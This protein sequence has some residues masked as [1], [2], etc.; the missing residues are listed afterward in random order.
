[1]IVTNLIL[2]GA[3]GRMGKAVEEAALEDERFRVAARVDLRLP[4]GREAEEAPSYTD[5]G[6]ALASHAGAVVVDFSSPMH[7][8]SRIGT[9]AAAGAPLVEG[10][11][12]LDEESE[13]ALTGAAK[14]VAV[15]AAPNLSPG[16]ALLRHALR[17]VLAPGDLRWDI[18]ILDR[19]HRGKKDAPSGTARLLD[20][21]IREVSVGGPS[22]PPQIASFRQGGVVGEHGVYLSADE[23]EMVLLHRALGRRV[24]ARG[25]LLAA[26]FAAAAD[27][28]L[29]TID[30]V[31]GLG[32]G[33][34]KGNEGP[35]SGGRS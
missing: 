14:R 4:E 16:I 19:H 11:T 28:G 15:V 29:Y 30:H 32:V 34:G 18:S 17:T 12:A 23:E 8:A 13:R 3:E 22:S 20:A 31:L 33:S 25:A 26:A 27:P 1:M 10:T 9:V 2:V 7:A 6:E 24:F 35:G 21:W 5:L